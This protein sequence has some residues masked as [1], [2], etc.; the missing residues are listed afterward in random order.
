MQVRIQLVPTGFMAADAPVVFAVDGESVATGSML[1]GVWG[2][3]DL[4]PGAHRLQ[5][6]IG[7]GR[8]SRKKEWTF[9][10]PASAP[11]DD[12]LARRLDVRV[13]YS[14]MWGTFGKQ[15]EL[16]ERDA[17]DPSTSDEPEEAIAE[18]APVRATWAIVAALVACFVLEQVAAISPGAQLAPSIETL[19]GFGGL[20]VPGTTGGQWFRLLACT[21]LHADVLHLL[22]NVIAIVMAGFLVERRLGWRWLTALYFVGGLGGSLMS[23][24]LN[25][26]HTVSVGASGAAMALFGGGLFVAQTL[27]RAYR[28][29]QQFALARVL[30]P[31][32]VPAFASK[33]GGHVD[34]GAHLGGT[35]AGLVLGAVLLLSYRRA[36]RHHE[37]IGR[38]RR[39]ALALVVLAPFVV[40]LPATAYGVQHASYP[41]AREEAARHA[42]LL[43]DSELEDGV[44]SAAKTASWVQRYPEDPRGLLYAAH[45]ANEAKNPEETIRY[46]EHAS[47]NLPRFAALFPAETVASFQAYADDLIAQA[48]V[49]RRLVPD[50]EL[51]VAPEDQA[52]AWTEHEADWL[53]RYPDDPRVLLHAAQGALDAGRYADLDSIA[54]HAIDTLPA[55]ETMLDTPDLLWRFEMLRAFAL[56]EQKRSVDADVLFA[57]LCSG[58]RGPLAAERATEAKVCSPR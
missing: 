29:T 42:A 23:L 17:S 21:F 30:I 57:R 7:S 22:C 1:T 10:V 3:V 14:R 19:M 35:L 55:V 58:A 9:E 38:F 54:A 6:T 31:S 44:P 45:H 48:R 50:A 37:G 39:S 32:L 49:A 15:L 2:E 26:G 51:I 4:E 53:Q 20:D 46:A 36:E 16:C 25:D 28:G 41:A 40:A 34:F 5:G 43:P 11:A 8:F 24:A 12:A 52:R 56:R 18:D 33:G 27:P 47:R 13:H